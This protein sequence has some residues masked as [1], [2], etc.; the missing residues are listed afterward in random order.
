MFIACDSAMISF[1]NM[2]SA[3]FIKKVV[4]IDRQAKEHLPQ[5]QRKKEEKRKQTR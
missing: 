3:Y 5:T 2:L 4:I 1:E